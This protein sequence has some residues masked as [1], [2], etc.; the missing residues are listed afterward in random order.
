MLIREFKLS[1]HFE[2]PRYQSPGAGA[3]RAWQG[4]SPPRAWEFPRGW[5]GQHLARDAES[6]S[7]PRSRG[8]AA[9]SDHQRPGRGSPPRSACPGGRRK[10][11]GSP[12]SGCWR[13]FRR[14]S[15]RCHPRAGFRC[16]C[17]PG[18]ARLRSGRSGRVPAPCSHARRAG[19]NPRRQ[20]EQHMTIT[21]VLRGKVGKALTANHIAHG[22]DVAAVAQFAPRRSRPRCA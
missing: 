15:G 21:E 10:P 17:Q 22:K 3:N 9:R 14:R 5:V 20:A 6:F 11:A 18:G 12:A 8:P 7:R 13:C 2:Q 16:G 4:A 19:G 1:R